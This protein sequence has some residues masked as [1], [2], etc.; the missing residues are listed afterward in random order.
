MTEVKIDH[1]L[2]RAD[3]LLTAALE[4]YYGNER[5]REISYDILERL[6]T[7]LREIQS[8]YVDGGLHAD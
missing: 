8:A 6:L 1:E 7:H 2:A 4:L 5:D 3:I